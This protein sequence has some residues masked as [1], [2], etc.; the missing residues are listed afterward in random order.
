[1]L[2]FYSKQTVKIKARRTD[3]R[4]LKC[5]WA[6][7]DISFLHS[8]WSTDVSQLTVV[9]QNH[10]RPDTVFKPI[11]VPDMQSCSTV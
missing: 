4:A 2:V 11:A 8:I 7:L 10:M 6:T 3:E 1:M 9:L 5:Y